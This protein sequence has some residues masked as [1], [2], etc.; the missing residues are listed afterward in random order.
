MPSQRIAAAATIA[1]SGLLVAGIASAPAFA[2]AGRHGAGGGG[3]ASDSRSG[4]GA[5]HTGAHDG[6][7]SPG[8]NRR[9]S[10]DT[11]S[12]GPSG[13]AH[14]SGTSASHGIG[15]R[16][17][18]SSNIRD[19]NSGWPSNISDPGNREY[20]KHSGR[21]GAGNSGSDG[22]ADHDDSSGHH[23]HHDHHGS[24]HHDHHD[25]HGRHHH[26]HGGDDSGSGGGGSGSSG[27]ST[28]GNN[29]HHQP[30]LGVPLSHHVRLAAMQ[31]PL[32]G[33]M[34]VGLPSVQ[35]TLAA[36]PAQIAA[37]VDPLISMLTDL[38]APAV[39]PQVPGGAS[40]AGGHGSADAGTGPQ[41][42]GQHGGNGVTPAAGPPRL[43]KPNTFSAG[44]D[45]AL[46]PSYRAGYGD[47]LRTAGLG[48][49]AAVAIPGFTGILVLTGAGGLVGYRQARAGHAVRSGASSVRFLS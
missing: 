44:R 30:G 22:R 47:Y 8:S 3:S 9:G 41:G 39:L 42:A 18:Q 5:G 26:G 45:L 6:S 33:L 4:A 21:N 24:D 1:A 37:Q 38:P 2:D 16:S 14:G 29:Q 48:E 10:G 19:R 46:Q 23:R 13:T 20:S 36:A 25:H 28:P 12:V 27:G 40:G 34:P 43:P 15:S 17:D 49:I 31:A 32:T 7:Q 35:T 11:G